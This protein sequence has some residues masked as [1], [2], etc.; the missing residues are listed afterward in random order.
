MMVDAAA[1]FLVGFV[2]LV[3]QIV[4]LRELT[5]AFFGIELIYLIALGVWLLASAIGR[6]PAAVAG[7]LRPAGPE[8]SFY[9]FRS[10]SRSAFSSFG[11]AA[12]F[13]EASRRLPPLPLQMAALIIALA[14]A[15]IISGL[16]FRLAAGVSAGKGGTLAGAYGIESAGALAGG[17]LVTICL[18]WGLQNVPLALGSGLIAAGAAL[19]LPAEGGRFLRRGIALTVATLAAVLLWYAGPLDR[20]MTALNHPG[21]LDSRDSPY[22]RVTVRELAGQVSVFIDDALAFE[23]EGPEAELFAH[24]ACLQHPNPKRILVIGGTI[25]GTLRELLRHGPARIDAVE[26]DR[27]LIATAQRHLPDEVRASLRNPACHLIMADPRRFL[28]ESSG[29][30]DLILIA[31]PEPASGRSNRFYTREFFAD[32]AARLRHG[33]IVAVRL[34]AAENFWT[35]AMINRTASI[36]RALSSIFPETLVLPGR[37]R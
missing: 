24:L 11:R 13:S 31:M 6:S 33:G 1:L 21:L 32:C 16:L 12:R 14:P 29:S 34:P 19:L 22:G 35:P 25:D 3:G 9:S 7:P 10:A 4:L 15:G 26:L 28:K 20:W 36:R 30:Y 17:L 8:P 27:T 18:R 5:V 37:R 2:S 23:T